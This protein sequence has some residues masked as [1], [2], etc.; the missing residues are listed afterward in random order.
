MGVE[1]P[2]AATRPSTLV[3]TTAIVTGGAQG[4]GGAT[5]LALLTNGANVCVADLDAERAAAIAARWGEDRVL[6]VTGD[7]SDPGLPEQVFART[8]DRFGSVDVLVNNAG[9]FWDAPVHR[10]TDDQFAAMLDIHAMV[11]FRMIREALCRWRPLAKD[12]AERGRSHYRKIVNVTSRAALT[13]LAGAANYAAG[14]A[15]LI[16]LTRSVARE[17]AKLA[18]NANA[19]A[20]G[21]VDTRFQQPVSDG[22]VIVSGGR[23]IPVGRRAAVDG[24]APRKVRPRS[25]NGR[26]ATP[27]EAADAILFL[28]SPLS[29]LI[30]GE[31]LEANA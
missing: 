20:F 22:N 23:E 1:L 31:V 6:T 28:C 2:S 7:L 29:N 15:A 17:C 25:M 30:N 9:F 8:V 13:G 18:I 12:E 3:G 14:K 5:V 10:M 4:I 19:V 26:N 24:E 16:G 21:G 11:P 27:E